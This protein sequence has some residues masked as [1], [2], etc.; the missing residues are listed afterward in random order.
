MSVLSTFLGVSS[1]SSEE[2]VL[3]LLIELGAQF[4][5]AEEGSL[6]VRDE[7]SSELVF[8]MTIGSKE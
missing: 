8:A 3:R 7:A 2:L 5:G 1:E 4:A 6:L